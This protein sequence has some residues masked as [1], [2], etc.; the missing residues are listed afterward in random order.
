VNFP[1]GQTDRTLVPYMLSGIKSLR[2]QEMELFCYSHVYSYSSFSLSLSAASPPPMR[3]AINITIFSSS[4]MQFAI[5]II[6]QGVGLFFFCN[7]I[8]SRCFGRRN[9]H[10]CAHFVRMCAFSVSRGVGF[11]SYWQSAAAAAVARS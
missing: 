1:N 3:G 6:S 4:S 10:R 5:G 2:W 11:L 7:V 8:A 9:E